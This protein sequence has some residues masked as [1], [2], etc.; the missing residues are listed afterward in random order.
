M[1]YRLLLILSLLCFTVAQSRTVYR[2]LYRS[3]GS[4]SSN[5]TA[6]PGPVYYNDAIKL[7][8]AEYN[9]SEID[10]LIKLTQ[11]IKPIQIGAFRQRSNAEKMY[12]Q[13]AEVVGED[14]EVIEED[15]LYKVRVV[16]LDKS[17]IKDF[18]EPEDSPM[19]VVAE[20]QTPVLPQDT[21]GLTPAVYDSLSVADSAAEIKASAA[22]V[23]DSSSLVV[24][25]KEVVKRYFLLNSKS[26]WLKRINYFGKSF[27][28]VNALIITIVVSI[29]TMFIMLF[30]ILLN[31]ARM[32]KE[33]NLKQ[34]L[35]ETY[36]GMIID[37]L[38]PTQSNKF[39]P[40]ASDT[41]GRQALIDQMI[42]V[43]EPEGDAEENL[44]VLPTWT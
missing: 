42:D 37:F 36:Q 16:T 44:A 35:A 6:R 22:P 26:P 23:L 24:Q 25:T 27:A 13:I 17:K 12:F 33:E 20:A 31:R 4:G 11:D 29:A 41:Y 40:I 18:L 30:V 28:L 14:V 39:R 34:Y 9:S 3:A 32:E 21:T 10:D 8:T 43:G 15:G 7:F 2:S 19:D 1:K 38:L 5:T